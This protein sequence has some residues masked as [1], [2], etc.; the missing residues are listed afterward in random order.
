MESRKTANEIIAEI[1]ST[2]EQ[3]GTASMILD[4][5]QVHFIV[6][7]MVISLQTIAELLAMTKITDSDSWDNEYG[8]QEETLKS[9]K[10]LGLT[11]ISTIKTFVAALPQNLKDFDKKITPEV[12]DLI[13]GFFTR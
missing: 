1:E 13:E 11:A 10:E 5:A 7:S 9:A 3:I 2:R 6:E 4:G 12:L 8:T